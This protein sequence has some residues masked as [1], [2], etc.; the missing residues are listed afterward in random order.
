[1]IACRHVC[2][3]YSGIDLYAFETGFGPAQNHECLNVHKR[4]SGFKYKYKY[5]YANDVILT[6]GLTLIMEC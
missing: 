3:R 1:M 2:W 6:Q 5:E 4:D